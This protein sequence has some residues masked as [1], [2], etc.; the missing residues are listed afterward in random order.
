MSATQHNGQAPDAEA[1][2]LLPPAQRAARYRELTEMH[3]ALAQQATLPEARAAHLEL[4][5]LW[6]RLAAQADH[7]SA[8]PRGA[9]GAEMGDPVPDPTAEAGL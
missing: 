9:D 7:E 4:A 6:T 3:L 8:R 5:A 2:T 1:L